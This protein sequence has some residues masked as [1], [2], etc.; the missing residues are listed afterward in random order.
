[1]K[2][3]EHV[4]EQ[5]ALYQTEHLLTQEV[6]RFDPAAAVEKLQQRQHVLAVDIGGDKIRSATYLVDDGTFEKLDERVLQSSE[7]AGYLAFLER[8]AEEALAR[9]LRVGIASATKMDGS[10]ITRTVNLPVFFQEFSQKYGADYENLFPGRSFVANDTIMGICGASTV[11]ARRGTDTRDVAFFI[12]ASG[13]GAS[14]ITDHTAIHVEAGHVPLMDALNPLGQTAKCGV[15]GKAYVC[16]ERVT[17]ARAEIEKLYRRQTGEAVDGVTLGR[18]YEQGHKLASVL[19]ETSALALAHA[20]RG[21]AERY[22]FSDAGRSVV[23]LHGGNF[24]IAKYRVAVKRNLD[25]LSHSSCGVAFSRDLS[26]NVC[27]DGA[28]VMAV[29]SKSSAP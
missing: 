26:E 12:C 18:M 17:A 4:P 9:G 2:L 10:S 6:C 22:S 1:M 27:L 20:I 11:L 8:L 15:D 3:P 19:Y 24:E 28:A 23:I 21:V 29:Y 16:V 14:V 5:V 13:L 25:K 7:G